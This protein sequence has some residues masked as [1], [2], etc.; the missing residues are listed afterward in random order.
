MLSWVGV[1]NLTHPVSPGT[2][3]AT[4]SHSPCDVM[5]DCPDRSKNLL[6]CG[7]Q[8]CPE[9]ELCCTLDG[10]CI[11]STWLCDGHRDCSDY[12]DEL[13]CGVCLWGQGGLAGTPDTFQRVTSLGVCTCVSAR[14]RVPTGMREGTRAAVLT[15]LAH[16]VWGQR[17]SPRVPHPGAPGHP[18]IPPAPGLP[19]QLLNAWTCCRNQ[20]PP[21]GERHVHG[22]ACDPGEC[23]LSQEC[24]S[25]CRRGPGLRSV[26]KPKCLWDY[27]SCR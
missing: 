7:P 15:S 3:V 1:W 25:H 18:F 24:H 23:H 20:D 10:L 2:E 11:P 4:S 26:W 22:D 27:R 9:G 12:S 17:V 19:P 6:N 16:S 14:A 21:G 5:G 8:P 13:G